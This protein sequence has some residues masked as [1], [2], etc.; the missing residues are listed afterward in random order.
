MI[1]RNTTA[2][3]IALS[4]ALWSGSALAQSGGSEDQGNREII[5]TAQR[6]AESVQ[7]V[8]ITIAAFDQ[9]MVEAS[10]SADI[11][12][13]NGITPNVILQTE[14]LV[15]N[16]PMF[17]IRGMSSADPD[18]NADPKISTI[19]N[20][21]YVPFVASTMLD[22]FD[23][24]RVEVLKGPQGVLYGKNNLAGTINIITKAPAEEAGGEVRLTGGSYGLKQVRGRLET[25]E[26]AG[27]VLAAKISGSYSDYNG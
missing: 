26:F 9:K 17:S 19:I 24:E 10:G 2:S 22:L 5:V 13:L 21:V 27:G 18:P 12:D 16:V 23:V 14:G 7:S 3:L 8:P 20:G 11:T 6:R 25:G 15:A 1:R 4:A